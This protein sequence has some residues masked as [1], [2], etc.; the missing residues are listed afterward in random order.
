MKNTPLNLR[1]EQLTDYYQDEIKGLFLNINTVVQQILRQSNQFIFDGFVI[2]L[3]D[4]EEVEVEIN[5]KNYHSN[6]RTLMFLPPQS[7]INIRKSPT[8]L[9]NKQTIITS[10]DMIMN[11]P[12]PIDTE[13]I[14]LSRRNPIVEINQQ[15][16]NLLQ[17][18]FNHINYTYQAK[19]NTYRKEIITSLLYAMTLEITN[20]LDTKIM[21]S[22]LK[23]EVLSDHFFLLLAKHYKTEHSVS[24]Y[25][26]KMA[27]TPK[28]LT[29]AI[30]RITGKSILTWINNAIIIEIKIQLKTTD[31]TILQI[32]EELNFSTPS[33]MIQFF[34]LHVGTTPLKYRHNAVW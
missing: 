31:K 7:F 18:Y 30:K 28:Y 8:S 10:L 13:I 34:K 14:N 2:S 22:P 11:M 32:S 3:I 21:P 9:H 23:N 17:Q 19:T 33:A 4:N 25:A 12:T 1:I 27:L 20:I 29:T 15:E 26:D 5:G 6:S 24:F 16:F